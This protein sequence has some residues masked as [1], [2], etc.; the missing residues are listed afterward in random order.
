MLIL[1]HPD[2]TAGSADYRAVFAYLNALTGVEIRLHTGQG[3]QQ[4]LTEIYLLGK[5]D[6][7]SQEDIEALPAVER[8]IRISE[9]YR[10]L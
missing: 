4:S 8:V 2:T 1:L 3:Q 9:E 6:A 10:I 5:T 7:L